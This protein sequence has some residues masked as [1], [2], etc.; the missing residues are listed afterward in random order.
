[1]P[2]IIYDSKQACF[3]AKDEKKNS[4][5]T[6]EILLKISEQLTNS[7]LQH[8]D[9]PFKKLRKTW[10]NNL[11]QEEKKHNLSRADSHLAHEIAISKI[12]DYFI[13]NM[14]N[15][16][17][18]KVLL[19]YQFVDSILSIELSDNKKSR[20]SINNFFVC[21]KNEVLEKEEASEWVNK[22]IALLSG[23]SKM[24]SSKKEDEVKVSTTLAPGFFSHINIT[25]RPSYSVA[26]PDDVGT[27]LH[28]YRYDD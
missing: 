15:P 18:L 21:I 4:H 14:N 2:Y 28:N 3:V 12:M 11:T 6:N 22:I 9:M 20:S 10:I 24:V 1:M 5:N 13:I 7:V 26:D 27:S 8:P 17:H 23:S 19:G 16:S 25:K